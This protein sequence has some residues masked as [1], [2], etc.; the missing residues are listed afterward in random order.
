MAAQ[1]FNFQTFY[2][3]EL[4]YLD[5]DLDY[6]RSIDGIL[7]EYQKPVIYNGLYK[8]A[9]DYFALQQ[10]TTHNLAAYNLVAAV[11][12]IAANDPRHPAVI[13]TNTEF[14]DIIL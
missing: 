9:W 1:T 3:Q 12:A 8:L 4:E 5:N 13:D 7:D 11:V 10:N 2:T 6:Y 14:I